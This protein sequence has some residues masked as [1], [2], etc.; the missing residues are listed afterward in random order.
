MHEFKMQK[1]IFHNVTLPYNEMLTKCKPSITFLQR[2]D[3]PLFLITYCRNSASYTILHKKL[4]GDDNGTTR[5]G[6]KI[7]PS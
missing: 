4:H 5:K 6:S 7:N 3:Y 2:V 1:I